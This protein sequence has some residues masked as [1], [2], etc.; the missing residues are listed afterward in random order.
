MNGGD[1]ERLV[2]QAPWRGGNVGGGKS[3][4]GVLERPK[5]RERRWEK[6]ESSGNAEEVRAA[7][8]DLGGDGYRR[9]RSR[10]SGASGTD[11]QSFD[12]RCEWWRLPES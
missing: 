3:T 7:A 1:Q 2:L 5:P 10:G 9:H 8:N 4:S 11:S 12:E 6:G